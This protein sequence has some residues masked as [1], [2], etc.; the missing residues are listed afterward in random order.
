[1]RK[2][3]G[4]AIGVALLLMAGQASAQNNG[5]GDPLSLISS[6][7][8]QP[9][10]SLA[11][12]NTLIEVTS[13]LDD[14][15]LHVVY[16]DSTCARLFS[17]PKFVSHKGA[18]AFS[19]DVDGVNVAGLAVIGRSVGGQFNPLPIP[20]ADGIH[21]R[22]HWFNFAA[23]FVRLVD[24]IAVKSAESAQTYSPLRSAASFGAPVDTSPFSTFLYL[25]CPGPLVVPFAGG[26]APALASPPFP[27][28]PLIAWMPAQPGLIFGVLY[29]DDE[30]VLIDFRLPCN[31]SSMFQLSTDIS[32]LYGNPANFLGEFVSYTELFTY[33][34]VGTSPP[35]AVTANPL[36]FTG[37]RAITISTDGGIWPGGSADDFGRLANGSAYNYRVN[38]NDNE[39]FGPFFVP[40][41]R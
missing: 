30:D 37:Y 19:P 21:V 15:A 35:P 38:G 36:T 13:P 8:I 25:I 18:I 9:F 28:P 1:M 27:A 32:P 6:A 10:W 34:V 22:G 40:G 41:L 2:T 29:D 33:N 26:P 11:A 17:A 39:L 12:D 24:P 14:N 3:I 23:D 16:F 20:D 5:T 31:C 4:V 7:V